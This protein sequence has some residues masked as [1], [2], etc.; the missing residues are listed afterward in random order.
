MVFLS[1]FTFLDRNIDFYRIY[2]RSPSC[3][4]RN[5]DEEIYWEELNWTIT[6]SGL[7]K[8]IM[9]EIKA[10]CLRTPSDVSAECTL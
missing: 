5:G 6:L 8:G 1:K 4:L 10:I 3:L 7:A 9:D 2:A